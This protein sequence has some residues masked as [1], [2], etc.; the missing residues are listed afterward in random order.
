MALFAFCGFLNAGNSILKTYG[1]NNALTAAPGGGA[2]GRL[3][4]MWGD[5][6]AVGGIVNVAVIENARSAAAGFGICGAAC[7]FRLFNG[8]EFKHKHKIRI[9]S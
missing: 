9:T 4:P 5:W 1:Q 6:G 2:C 7:N 3:S 8:R